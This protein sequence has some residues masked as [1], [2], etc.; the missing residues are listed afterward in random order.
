MKKTLFTLVVIF[1]AQYL[2]YAQCCNKTEE[3]KTTAK[4]C[5]STDSA[6]AETTVTA[7][8]FHTSRRCETC[9]AV[10]AVSQEAVQEYTKL[11]VPFSSINIEE[12]EQQALVEKYQVS[13]Q[14]LLIVSNGKTVNL[15]N[16]AFMNARTNP[17]KLKAKIKETIDSML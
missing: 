16:E 6:K 8:Y 2:S 9:K 7:Y 4:T 13:G 3:A 11:K 14:T 12:Q 10:E 5:C 17:D 15:T 1:I